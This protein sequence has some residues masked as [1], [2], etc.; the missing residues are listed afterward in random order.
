[1]RF[2]P[3]INFRGTTIARAFLLNAVLVGVTTALTIEVRRIVDENRFTRDFPDR[4]H[5]VFGT[6]I[7]SILI[8]LSA[9]TMLRFILGAGGG[10]LAPKKP[11]P[12]FF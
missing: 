7:A 4:P 8:G 5:K 9:Y 2:K 12:G 11:Y 10:M 6:T 3:L 1:M